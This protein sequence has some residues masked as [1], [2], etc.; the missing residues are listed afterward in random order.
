MIRHLLVLAVS[1]L[2]VTACGFHLRGPR[3][4]PFAS[5]YLAMDNYAE[6]TVALKRQIRSSGTTQVADKPEEAELI[7]QV[8]RNDREKNIL[9][10]NTKGIA[11]EHQLKQR[12]GFR[13]IGRDGREITSL[14]EITV[15]RDVSFNDSD[16]IAKEQEEQMLF[17]DMENDLVQQLMRRL[18]ATRMPAS[19]SS[20]APATAP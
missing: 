16:T 4:L 7:L 2:L 20:P 13:L 6:L 9:S 12:L 17:R 3:P 14:S 19:A 8:V 15:T 10:L 18:S 11:R 1:C 5:I